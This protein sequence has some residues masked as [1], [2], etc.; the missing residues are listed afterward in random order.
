[1]TPSTTMHDAWLTVHLDEV[2]DL[3]NEAARSGDGRG[4][5][6]HS[7]RLNPTCDASKPSRS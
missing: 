1:M 6:D 4:P 2:T 7:C 3:W 5:P